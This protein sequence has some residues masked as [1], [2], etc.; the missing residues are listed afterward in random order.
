MKKYWLALLMLCLFL[1][2]SGSASAQ[3]ATRSDAFRTNSHPV[4]AQGALTLPVLFGKNAGARAMD[5]SRPS[6]DKRVEAYYIAGIYSWKTD[7]AHLPFGGLHHAYHDN[8]SRTKAPSLEPY[9]KAVIGPVYLE[10]EARYGA[11]VTTEFLLP[12]GRKNHEDAALSYSLG[13][14]YAIGPVTIGGLYAV[15]ADGNA[16]IP[17]REGGTRAFGSD[18]EPGLFFFNGWAGKPGMNGYLTGSN[19]GSV[20]LWQIKAGYSVN[21][22]LN[23]LT[24]Y[25]SARVG[26]KNTSAALVSDNIGAE[27]D[28]TA[29][30]RI[31][32]N[33]EYVM[34]AAYFWTGDALK[35]SSSTNSVGNNYMVT[36]RLSLTF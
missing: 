36:H 8:T 1:S 14:R 26:Q 32:G 34:G 7:Q 11:G 12:R 23:I 24:S 15:A 10:G 3:T 2:F 31:F 22:N 27:L 5:A 25:T 9:F 21:N 33:L 19:P 29:S 4:L 13:A 28:V 18:L 17:A 16:G 6:A 35:N 30:Y 20:N